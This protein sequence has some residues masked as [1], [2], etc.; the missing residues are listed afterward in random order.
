MRVL[1]VL[2]ELRASGSEVMARV[3]KDEWAR[4]GVELDILATG[5]KIG[6]Y[7][8]ELADCGYQIRHLPLTPFA[9]FARGFVRHLREERYDVVHIHQEKA[10]LY[11]GAL[12][13]LAG[14]RR[15]VRSVNSQFEFDGAL[16]MQRKIQRALL[17]A[18]SVQHVAISPAVGTNEWAR[19]RNPTTLVYCWFDAEAFEP[20]GDEQRA[21]ARADLDIPPEAFVV[22]SVGNCA[23]VKNHTALLRAIAHSRVDLLYLHAGSEDS[24]RTER[25]LA[26]ELAIADQVRFLGHV[27]DVPQLL[28]A[29][30]CFVMPSLYEGMGVAAL[31]ALATGT[32]C[33]LSDVPGL[34]DLRPFFP[35]V[36]WVEPT[37]EAIATAIDDAARHHRDLRREEGPRL[38]EAARTNFAPE[39]LVPELVEVYRGTRR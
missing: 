18:M 8:S 11:L 9:T 32:P 38:A 31:E 7:A 24:E 26:S 12:A 17:R 25:R 29:V 21:A 15:I 5:D 27:S 33:I 6:T 13:R 35:Q 37:P 36:W 3:A 19:Y 22:G 16:R 2:S 4:S 30:D 28:H 10:N 39:R 23:P 20:A 1:W 34:G 14:T